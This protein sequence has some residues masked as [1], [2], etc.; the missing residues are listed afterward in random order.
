VFPVAHTI[1]VITH[2]SGFD[3]YVYHI[4]SHKD[5]TKLYH[6][7]NERLLGRFSV[8]QN[9]LIITDHS[10]FD[11]TEDHLCSHQNQTNLNCG[12]YRLL[13][14]FLLLRTNHPDDNLLCGFPVTRNMLVV[15]D[16]S[17]FNGTILHLVTHTSRL[18][19]EMHI[20]KTATEEIEMTSSGNKESHTHQ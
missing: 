16:Y 12:N 6:T 7:K 20:L 1:L 2:Y 10:G 8:V 3:G 5:P 14:G 11:G 4:R 19:H 17:G 15:T 9:I 18:A 13:V